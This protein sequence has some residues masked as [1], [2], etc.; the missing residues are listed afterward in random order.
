MDDNELTAEEQAALDA[1][2]NAPEPEPEVPAQ[3]P[4]ETPQDGATGQ[5]APE[6]AEQAVNK[7]D[8]PTVPYERFKEANDRRK[9]IERQSAEDR[10]RY[11]VRLEEVLKLIPQPAAAPAQERPAMPDPQQDPAGY[12]IAD[13]QQKGAS[14]EQ[15]NQRFAAFEQ[16]QQAI[17]IATAIRGH[18]AAHE[19]VF[20]K[21]AP[22]YDAAVDHLKHVY[23]AQLLANGMGDPG[24]RRLAIENEATRIS[25]M[26][27][28]QGANIA[29]RFYRLAQATGYRQAGE[30][31]TNGQAPPTQAVAAAVPSQ[32][33]RLRMV[34]QG[35]EQSRGLGN[36]R[37]N[38]PAPMT[39]AKLL[40]MDDG[41]FLEAMKKSK[42][43]RRLMGA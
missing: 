38:G 43:A 8:P 35:Q 28:Q 42:E 4:A 34:Q 10:R 24:Q 9:E 26:A 17:Q 1:Q 25:A 2:R 31:M 23:D 32:A 27:L 13:M 12:I 11:E 16:Q 22:D 14:I 19:E 3:A 7:G 18:T 29:E 33:D 21:E 20:R 39:A 30:Q 5:E 37:G 15:I 40:D 41:D 36:A 6:G